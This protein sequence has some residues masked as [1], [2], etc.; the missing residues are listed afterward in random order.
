MDKKVDLKKPAK[1]RKTVPSTELIVCS[2]PQYLQY[3]RTYFVNSDTENTSVLSKIVSELR[4]KQNSYKK[5]DT[6]KK[7]YN[8]E[9]FITM[10]AI[11]GK[12]LTSKMLCYY[13]RRETCIFYDKVRQG[14]QWTLERIDNTYGHSDKNTVIACLE[15][16][17]KRRDS[18]SKAFC[19]AK[20]LVIKKV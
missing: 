8:A 17:L 11:V 13:C 6:D 5:Q 9:T 16:N 19:F 18:N 1:E 2:V 15:C 3:L 10:D 4:K 20:Q 12:L 7:K 14:N